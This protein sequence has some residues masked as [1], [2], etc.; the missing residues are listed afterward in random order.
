MHQLFSR[1]AIKGPV[2]FFIMSVSLIFM[3][4][5]KFSLVLKNSF[6]KPN[7]FFSA[8]KG[9]HA[10]NK[11]L[12]NA[13]KVLEINRKE[14]KDEQTQPLFHGSS[15]WW[16]HK[17]TNINKTTTKGK[18]ALTGV[19]VDPSRVGLRKLDRILRYG[20]FLPN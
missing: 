6:N 12:L 1:F 14:Y 16:E 9:I 10:I 11:H 3:M 19:V 4:F 20:N 18:S 17:Y 7:L 15:I 2:N 5:L 8:T 13:Y